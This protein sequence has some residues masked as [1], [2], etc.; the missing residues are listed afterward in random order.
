[1]SDCSFH[2][3]PRAGLDPIDDPL[4]ALAVIRLAVHV[5][6]VHETVVLLLDHARCGVGITVVAGTECPDDVIDVA[7]CLVTAAAGTDRV[8]AMVVASVRPD[9]GPVCGVDGCDIG[10]CDVGGCDVDHVVEFDPERWI[11]MSEIAEE[12]GIELLEW[13]VIGRDVVTPRDQ[14]GESPR[15]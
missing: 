10:G 2:R 1:M 9:G 4:T 5:P 12:A 13:F 6:H 14:L 11:E 8:G 15:W 3:V 7:E